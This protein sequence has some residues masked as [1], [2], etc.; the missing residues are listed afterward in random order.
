MGVGN[1]AAQYLQPAG[2]LAQTAAFAAAEGAGYVNL[3]RGL[4]KG[5]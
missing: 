5:K 3:G 1:A 2:T 4:R